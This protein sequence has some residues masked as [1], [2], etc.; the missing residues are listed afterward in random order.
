MQE[1]IIKIFGK[2]IT[3]EKEEK[4]ALENILKPVSLNK[5]DSFL[6]A[7]D[8]SGKIGFIVEGVLEMYVRAENG[9][10]KSLDFFFP[11]QFT[12][13]FICYLKDIPCEIN[14][15]AI[16]NSRLLV[17][18]KEEI[19]RLY[20][21]SFQFQKL[22]RL[23]AQELFVELATRVRESYLS[24]AERYFKI[25]KQKKQLIH[26]IPQYKLA[27][28]LNISPEWLSTIRKKG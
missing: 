5:N 20:E 7:G 25:L 12:S 1:P 3:L 23:I 19:E 14:I 15:R 22:G 10:E 13:D 27:S 8:K 21:N 17:F 26:H 11:E 2:Y 9:T 6:E 24:P 16:T 4:A 28:F 18:E